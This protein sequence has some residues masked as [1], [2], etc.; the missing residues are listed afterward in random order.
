MGKIMRALGIGGED[1]DS[2]AAHEVIDLLRLE[3]G[4][5]EVANDIKRRLK[6]LQRLL[7]KNPAARQA[8]IGSV[9]ELE[10]NLGL[11]EG[12]AIQ[13]RKDID[14]ALANLDNIIRSIQSRR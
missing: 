12:E 11:A 6:E 3:L 1:I 8:I 13:E 4:N 7:K 2:K 10:N 5:V 14:S 9:H